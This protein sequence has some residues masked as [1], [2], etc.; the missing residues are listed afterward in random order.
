MFRRCLAPQSVV[1]EGVYIEVG[2]TCIDIVESHGR[3]SADA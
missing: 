3:K 1:N 2:I